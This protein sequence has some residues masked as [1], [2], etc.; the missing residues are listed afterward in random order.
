MIIGVPL[1][2]VGGTTQ[3]MSLT[4]EEAFAAGI[5]QQEALVTKQRE[6]PARLQM[7]IGLGFSCVGMASGLAIWCISTVGSWVLPEEQQEEQ[8]HQEEPIPSNEVSQN[9]QGASV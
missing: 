9:P 3:P 8:E 1:I 4:R 2:L 5:H 6:S 7:F